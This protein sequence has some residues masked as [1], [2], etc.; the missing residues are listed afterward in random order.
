M[1]NV[2]DTLTINLTLDGRQAELKIGDIKR[3]LTAFQGAVGNTE[4]SVKRL[5]GAMT[6]VGASFRRMIVTVGALRFALMD[7][8]DV[9]GPLTTGALRAGGEIERMRLLMEG[10]SKASDDTS[11]RLEAM[12]NTEFVFNMAKNAPFEVKD[13]SDSFVKLKSAGLDPTNGSMQALVDSVA[14]FGGTSENLKRASVAIQQMSG[15]GV[16]SMEELRQQLG[17]AVPNAM[18]L[19]ADGM[20]VSMGTLAKMVGDGV[21]ESGDALN[22]MIAM[23]QV[24]NGGSAQKMMDSFTGLVSR[25]KTEWMLFQNAISEA[26]FADAAKQV[27]RD[28]IALFQSDAGRSFAVDMGETL[29]AVT[30]GLRQTAKY[31]A[32]NLSWVRD[33]IA[34]YGGAFMSVL[35]GVGTLLTEFPLL[36][37]GAAL[38]FAGFLA[39]SKITDTVKSISE[40]FAVKKRLLSESN[41]QWQS[42]AS[43]RRLIA[44]KE[45]A[46]RQAELQAEA[47]RNMQAVVQTQALHRAKEA[48]Y[49]AHM[50][51]MAAAQARYEATMRARAATPI[52]GGVPRPSVRTAMNQA[53]ELAKMKMTAIVLGQQTAAYNANADAAVK[54]SVAAGQNLAQQRALVIGLTA[55]TVAARAATVAMNGMKFV[56]TALGGWV[57]IV[58]T[59]LLLGIPA[60]LTWS[61][62][63]KA[64]IAK[65]REE[66]NRGLSTEDTVKSAD[67][68]MGAKSVALESERKVLQNLRKLRGDTENGLK[69]DAKSV[70]GL[71]VKIREQ[72]AKVSKLSAELGELGRLATDARMQSSSNAGRERAERSI[73]ELQRSIDEVGADRTRRSLAIDANTTRLQSGTTSTKAKDEFAKKGLLE[74]QKT[75]LETYTLERK[76][77]DDRIKA[78]NDLISRSGTLSAAEQQGL[79]GEAQRLID[80]KQQNETNLTLTRNLLNAPGVITKE[81]KPKTTKKKDDVGTQIP[82]TAPKDRYD[83]FIQSQRLLNEKNRA[84]IGR[85]ESEL[86]TESQ[87]YADAQ[88]KIDEMVESGA[89]DRPFIGMTKDAEGRDVATWLFRRPNQAEIEDAVGIQFM[90]DKT[91]VAEEGVRKY[92]AAMRE[93]S[94]KVREAE[95]LMNNPDFV[96]SSSNMTGVFAIV[97]ELRRFQPIIEEELNKVG[98]SFDTFARKLQAD[99]GRIDMGEFGANLVAATRDNNTALIFNDRDRN[100]ERVRQELNVQREI[101]DARTRYLRMNSEKS[102][103]EL[104]AYSALTD[105][106]A[107]YQTSVMER[108]ARENESALDRTVRSWT[109]GFD[110]LDKL[111]ASTAENFIDTL[112]NGIKEGRFEVGEF[113]KT[114][115]AGLLRITLQENLAE[116][117]KKVGAT[118]STSIRETLNIGNTGTPKAVQGLA[119]AALGAAEI[120][121]ATASMGAFNG[122][123]TMANTD[124]TLLTTSVKNAIL[125]V[126]SF[127]LSMQLNSGG[128]DTGGLD[129]LINAVTGGGGFGGG[130]LDAPLA[131]F[132][133]FANG[134]IMTNKG[135]LPLRKYANGGI[136]RSAQ[137]AI[138]GEGDRPEAFVPLPDGRSIPVTMRASGGGAQ[139]G[140]SSSPPV[141]NIYNQTSQEV[142]GEVKTRFDG[143]QMILDVVLTN[144]SQPGP[145]RDGM[146]SSLR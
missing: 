108:L 59:A 34:V 38:A 140:A 80:L 70:E 1:S 27:L 89:L 124:L 90:S 61:N 40:F 81:P 86:I 33:L 79:T 15:K 37:K 95:Q 66:V 30:N 87:L 72:E 45:A 5:E 63:A 106:F 49:Q 69:L 73:A 21:V 17:E 88:S 54:A 50:A 127:A 12:A 111:I 102:A 139:Q 121:P 137:F 18:K 71:D 118:I 25:T 44:L 146:K 143:S 114:F 117:V 130:T 112:V 56:F 53:D 131:A 29:A 67:A 115:A 8:N 85:I 60:W 43:G 110:N 129:S 120:N 125:A 47:A 123:L 14:K 109:Q 116:S 68:Q 141:V 9:F 74:R 10:L 36:V 16:I 46:D 122:A 35:K 62:R 105:R 77:I 103:E 132:D 28:L 138:F 98:L 24:V 41:T 91:K 107:A 135:S 42:Q 6:G 65:V 113:F 134:G 11:K 31:I 78:V 55:T 99:A 83:R 126:E 93:S 144:M 20:G 3:T 39:V 51:R 145:F 76:I 119:G 48:E 128:Q 100:A 92:T 26:G 52:M 32:E 19:M 133:M 22:R 84:D 57:G 101:F 4:K 7:I 97:Q 2:L 75:H 82:N 96:Q 136:A 23:M 142:T 94:V 104:S 13:L 64:A 58:T